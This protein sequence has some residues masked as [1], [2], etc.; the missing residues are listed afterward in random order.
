MIFVVESKDSSVSNVKYER[1]FDFI[2]EN[3]TNFWYKRIEETL[4][5]NTET[6]IA[7][8]VYNTAY[9]RLRLLK[10]L[11]FLGNKVIYMD[12]DS[13]FFVDELYTNGEWK[14]GFGTSF[15]WDDF[16]DELGGGTS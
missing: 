10:A 1:N 16:T 13:I 2:S 7:I 4:F 14:S 3:A 9:E 12:S 11:D 8:A 5:A 6:N 15:S